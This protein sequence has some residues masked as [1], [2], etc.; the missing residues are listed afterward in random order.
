MTTC[1]ASEASSRSC[2]ALRWSVSPA[3]H[4]ATRILESIAVVIRRATRASTS[5]SPSAPCQFPGCQSP[6]ISQTRFR[7][8]PPSRARPLRLLQTPACLPRELPIAAGFPAESS[9]AL[10]SSPSPV[11]SSPILQFLTL[12]Q[13]SLLS[14][15]LLRPH[16]TSA[17]QYLFPFLCGNPSVPFLAFRRCDRVGQ[18]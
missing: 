13:F 2:R 6:H 12:S 5:G 8:A 7:P 17:S 14:L 10:C 16:A 11:S 18:P 3:S 9:P 1:P 4:N 15:K